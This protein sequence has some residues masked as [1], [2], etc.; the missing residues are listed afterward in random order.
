LIS[1]E[2]RRLLPEEVAVQALGHFN[3]K[4]WDVPLEVYGLV[5]R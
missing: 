4:G 3:V 5:E 1:A 2:V